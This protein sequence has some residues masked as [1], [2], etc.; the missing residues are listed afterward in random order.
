VRVQPKTGAQV[1]VTPDDVVTV[2]LLSDRPVRA[3]EIRALEH[4]DA[5]AWPLAERQWL[6]GWLLRTGSDDSY[7]TNSAVPLD[8][9]ATQSAIPAII[10][11]YRR[12]D[13]VPRLAVPDRLLRIPHEGEHPTRVMVCAVN[14]ADADPDVELSGVAVADAPDGTRWVGLSPLYALTPELG[15]ALLSWGA[16]RGATRG[17]IRIPEDDRAAAQLARS[18]GFALHHHGRYIT[19][20]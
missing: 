20:T 16:S 18:L 7:V 8:I 5:L 14:A 19:L 9:S 17:Y 15:R 2:R 6:D 3:S 12:R 11:W 1:H 10:D 13:L 4:A